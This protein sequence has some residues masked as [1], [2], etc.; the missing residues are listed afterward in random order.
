MKELVER[1]TRAL[2]D[3]PEEFRA[4]EIEGTKVTVLEIKVSKQDMACLLGN[5]GKT[6]DLF[7]RQADHFIPALHL[8]QVASI[9]SGLTGDLFST[10][11][12]C[13]DS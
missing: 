7:P 5:K 4:Q 11:G 9:R 12:S 8:G 13:P 1:I 10:D 3:S 2:V 6:C